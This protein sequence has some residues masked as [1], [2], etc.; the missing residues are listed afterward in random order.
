MSSAVIQIPDKPTHDN[1]VAE[2]EH[3]PSIIYV[4]NSALPICKDFT[5]QYEKLAEKHG[6]GDG[7]ER[8]LRFCQL[9]FS[10]ETSMMF[11]FSPNQ[12]PVLVLISEG[13]WA[14]TLMSPTI[15]EL[16]SGVAELLKRSG[17]SQN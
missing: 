1:I 10:T 3:N 9:D 17:K 11:K 13:H 8:L 14:R 2:S 16:E 4:C 7:A 6:K 12:L 15:Q 5:P